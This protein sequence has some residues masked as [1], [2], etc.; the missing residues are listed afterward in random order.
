MT[1]LEQFS[2]RVPFR[3]ADIAVA[4]GI[5][6]AGTLTLLPAIHRSRERMNQAGCVFNLQQLGNSLGQ[7]AVAASVL[8]VSPFAPVRH[9]RGYVCGHPARRGGAE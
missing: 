8:A 7:Y 5:F 1:L 2:T 4:A 9:A 3:W 6:I